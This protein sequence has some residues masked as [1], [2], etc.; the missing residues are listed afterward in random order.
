M[1]KLWIRRETVTGGRFYGLFTYD[2]RPVLGF[3]VGR[4]ALYIGWGDPNA[5]REAKIDPPADGVQ[6]WGK[7]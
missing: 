6:G 2:H 4:F 3:I 1:N 7:S 5:H